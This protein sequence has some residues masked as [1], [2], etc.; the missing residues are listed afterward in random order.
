MPHIVVKMYPGR[1]P[2]Q[3]SRLVESITQSV[4]DSVLCDEKSI[5]ISIEE[6]NK[7][8]WCEKVYKPEILGRPD[9]LVKKPGY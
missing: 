6:I 1:T 4:M 5:S 2:E 8:D 9:I 3:K 7:E